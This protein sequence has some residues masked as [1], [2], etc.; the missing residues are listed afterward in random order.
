[1]LIKP[2]GPFRV[3]EKDDDTYEL[4]DIGMKN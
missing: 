1:M 4:E 3:I 2:I